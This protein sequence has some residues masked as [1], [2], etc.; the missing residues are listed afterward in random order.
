MTARDPELPPEYDRFQ[1]RCPECRFPVSARTERAVF[2][3]IDDH[4]EYEERPESTKHVGPSTR[5]L[6]IA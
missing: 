6:S 5:C 4:I 1:S 3:A 2:L